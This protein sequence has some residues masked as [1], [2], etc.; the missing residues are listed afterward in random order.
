MMYRGDYVRLKVLSLLV[1]RDVALPVLEIMEA[2]SGRT[3]P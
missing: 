2:R 1:H 3:A